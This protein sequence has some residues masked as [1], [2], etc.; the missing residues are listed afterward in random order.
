MPAGRPP[1]PPEIKEAQGTLRHSRE[2]GKGTDAPAL[3]TTPPPPDRFTARDVAVDQIGA[4]AF[5]TPTN[6]EMALRRSNQQ[7]VLAQ[8]TW[9]ALTAVLIEW[10]VLR[11]SDLLALETLCWE[12]SRWRVLSG[13]VEEEGST[14]EQRNGD[15][16]LIAIV[17]HPAVSQ[18]D[19]AFANAE[20][21]M[22]RFGLTPSDRARVRAATSAGVKEENPFA[23]LRGPRGVVGGK[24]A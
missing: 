17:G 22:A 11:Q 7:R 5:P 10:G 20:R 12:Y 6:G 23:A 18:M 2:A 19:R 24:G 15:G 8:E 13:V 14:T 3:K 21:L 1:L 16:N 9:A 4:S